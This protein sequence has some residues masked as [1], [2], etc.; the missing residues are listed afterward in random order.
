MEKSL[1]ELWKED[2]N[3]KKATPSKILNDIV[4]NEFHDLDEKIKPIYE[5]VVEKIDCLDCA[6]CCK[7]TVTTFNE[8]DIA[9]ISKFLGINKKRFIDLYT[10]LDEGEYTTITTPC[11]FLES[12]NKCAIY[13]VRPHACSSFPHL[14]R[15]KFLNRKR[16]HIENYLVCPITY[17]TINQISEKTGK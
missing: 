1:V 10:I 5:A 17:H 15:K 6:N 13:E 4:V 12:D 16:V 7:T 14:G 8:E 2:A 11:P 3:K 9:R